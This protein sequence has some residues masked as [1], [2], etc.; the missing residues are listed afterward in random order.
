[1]S[2]PAASYPIESV[3]NAARVLLMLRERRVLRVAEVAAELGLAR[4]SAHRMVTTLQS[5]GLL[6]QEPSRGYVA[7]PQ[8]IQLGVAVLGVS[9]LRAEAR[10]TLERLCRQVGETVHLV[11]LDG[12]R[13]V[14]LDG[15]EGSFAIRAAERT[16]DRAPAH[17]SAAGKVLLA[18]LS[19][20]QLHERYP[21]PRL[22]GG[23]S[24]AIA[25]RR[26]LEDELARVRDRGYA[27]NLGESEVGLHALA[28]PVLDAAGG[29]RAA[30]SISGPSVRLT[31][32]RLDE[33]VPVLLAAAREVGASLV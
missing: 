31:E 25:S 23:T 24:G 8:L 3:E 33:Q 29:A 14:F 30:I 19:R 1:M 32:D 11:V 13:I 2:A 6:R 20:E 9:D 12:S 27:T 7:G 28:V 15:V 26:V 10:P 17:A 4:S 22:S 5:Q 18:A 16:G 21:A